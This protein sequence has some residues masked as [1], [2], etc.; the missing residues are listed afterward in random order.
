MSNPGLLPTVDLCGT[1]V[2]R[3]IIGGN[4]LRGYS[5]YSE[6]LDTEMVE[7]YTPENVTKALLD[8]EKN[9]INTMQS[10][11]DEIVF[12]FVRRYREK[13]GTM[14]WIVQ[15]ASEKPDTDRNI[16]DIAAEGAFAIY[17]HGSET[18]LRWKEGRVDTIVDHLKTIRDTGCAVGLCSH[19]P[20][21]LR[22]VEEK[23]WDI[24]FYTACVYNLSRVERRGPAASGERVAEP[25]DDADRDVMCEFIRSTSKPCLAFKLLA[26]GRNCTSRR[27][28]GQAFRHVFCSIK[29]T[30]AAIVGM[31]Q[32]HRDQ[33]KE[34]CEIVRELLGQHERLPAGPS[35][36]V[37]HGQ[38]LGGA[39]SGVRMRPKSSDRERLSP[40]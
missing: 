31:F 18:D 1:A 10:R 15:T 11:G 3:L 21:V 22:Y 6:Q 23:G 33:V 4:P 30:D 19:M 13:G 25:F 38:D 29:P 34:N 17:F 35:P 5:H 28:V 32:K 2:T 26:A 40:H 7:Y 16:R 8:C 14:N 12:S 36:P 24:D 37:A 39:C 27:T 20:E 9:G